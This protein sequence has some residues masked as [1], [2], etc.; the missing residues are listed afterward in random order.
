[1]SNP[2]REE[3]RKA[4]YGA[5]YL[6]KEKDGL[7]YRSYDGGRSWKSSHKY[8]KA[9]ADR[10]KEE[11]KRKF[12]QGD[13]L[14]TFGGMADSFSRN[15]KE[16]FLEACRRR[17]LDTLILN[18]DFAI[19]G[20]K[21]NAKGLL[22]QQN[23]D[24]FEEKNYIESLI[25]RTEDIIKKELETPG[26]DSIRTEHV[27]RHFIKFLEEEKAKVEADKDNIAPDPLKELAS[28]EN[29]FCKGMPM[30]EVIEHF[31]PLATTLSKHNNQPFLSQ[32]QFNLFL[33]RAFLNQTGIEQQKINMGNG[34]K[35]FVIKRFYQFYSIASV[36][37]ESTTQCKDKYIRLL[38]DNFSNWKYEDL[39]GNFSQNKSKREW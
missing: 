18:Y 37:Y 16:K 26:F 28:Q 24:F 31:K 34:E 21:D 4:K 5:N 22:N 8:D 27:G 33:K 6:T 3:T 25:K 2:D 39:K 20:S 9:E 30:Q 11:L 32:E 14:T 35:Y 7:T 19:T 29:Q 23:T 1:M 36:Q 12:E 17:D 13:Y 38:S 15:Y 10:R